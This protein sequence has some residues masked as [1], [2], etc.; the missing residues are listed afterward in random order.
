MSGAATQTDVS[1]VN[2][3]SRIGRLRDL[4]AI[5][6]RRDALSIPVLHMM[7]EAGLDRSLW[8]Q[9]QREEKAPSRAT[10]TK[11]RQAL[12]RINSAANPRQAMVWSVYRAFMAMQAVHLGLDAEA[13]V[14]AVPDDLAQWRAAAPAR[15]RAIYLTVTALD[16]PISEM[17]EAVGITKQGVSKLLREIEDARDDGDLD[18]DLERWERIL[19]GGQPVAGECL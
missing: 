8:Y 12:V 2:R 10:L 9:W 13:V 1:I 6:D 16:I 4:A 18:Q 5:N 14:W 17:A 3:A 19:T 7:C 15:H 11:L